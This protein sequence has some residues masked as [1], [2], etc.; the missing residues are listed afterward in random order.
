VIFQGAGGRCCYF[1]GDEGTQKGDRVIRGD[2]K[3]NRNAE[4]VKSE[5]LKP[6]CGSEK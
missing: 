2:Q 1:S 3:G 6:I 5:E 4:T